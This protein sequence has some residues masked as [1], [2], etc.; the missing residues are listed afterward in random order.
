MRL[1]GCGVWLL[2][3]G[4]LLPVLAGVL[5]DYI[6]VGL[7]VNCCCLGL[8]GC[9]IALV[10]GLCFVVCFYL[11]VLFVMLVCSGLLFC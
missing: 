5:F 2:F 9:G 7:V 10:V 4:C 3:G 8:F 6:T 1:F 11:V